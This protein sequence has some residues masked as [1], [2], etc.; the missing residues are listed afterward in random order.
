M[1]EDFLAII[2]DRYDRLTKTEKKVADFVLKCPRKVLFMSI[3]DLSEC[4][5]V[6]DTS[7]FRFCQKMNLEGI[8]EFKV[9]LSLSLRDKQLENEA[10]ENKIDFNASFMSLSRN[11]LNI[12][13]GMLRQTSEL[14]NKSY[15]RAVSRAFHKAGRV[16]FFGVG[17]DLMTAISAAGTFQRIG[18]KAY[19]VEATHMQMMAASAMKKEEVAVIFSS[20]RAE[21]DILQIAEQAK[22]NE[23]FLIC[24]T[25]FIKSSLTALADLVL[26]VHMY[27]EQ[28]SDGVIS[29][30]INQY[31]LVNL[32]YAEYYRTYFERA[33]MKEDEICASVLEKIC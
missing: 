9:R 28:L 22:L 5:G 8:R 2:N 12:N 19:Y 33:S 32:I 31:F 6:S 23:A 30:E 21:R 14:L 20:T 18:V 25:S 15:I 24:I 26:P 29:P 3:M 4:C 1:Q 16:C 13:L 7:V 17:A 27:K 11:I 10:W